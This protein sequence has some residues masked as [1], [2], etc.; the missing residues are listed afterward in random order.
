MPSTFRHV[1][2]TPLHR[3]SA[4]LGKPLIKK[5]TIWVEPKLSAAIE[6]TELTDDGLVRHATFKGLA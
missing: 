6:L 1:W 3:P 4:P 2:V 5:G